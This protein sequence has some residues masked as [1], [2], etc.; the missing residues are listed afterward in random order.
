M[1]DELIGRLRVNGELFQKYIPN[2]GGEIL[3]QAA[4]AI[5]ELTADC[6]MYRKCMTDEHNKAARLLWDKEHCWI[7]VTER[8]PKYGER[9]LVFGGF[10][11]YV[12]YYDKNRYGGESW[13]KLN[14][15]SHYC[16]PTHWQPLPQ[17]PK[18]E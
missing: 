6:D 3:L 5:E 12:A 8:L 16:N 17:P 18:E 9:V 10:T 13:H 11:M 4:D 7:P 2:A 15:K 1:Y 14:S